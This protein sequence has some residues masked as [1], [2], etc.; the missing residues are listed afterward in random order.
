MKASDWAGW[1]SRYNKDYYGGGL[2]CMV[3]V[4]AIYRGLDYQVG[5]LTSM[6]PG[7]FPVAIGS[8]LALMGLII[9]LGA[10]GAVPS[11]TGPRHRPE[12]RGWSCILLANIAFVLLGHYG[13]LVPATF[14]VVFISALG[15]RQNT[16]KS[17]LVLALAM[18]AIC[19]IV[20]AWGLQL[21]FPLFRWG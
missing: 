12:W 7:Y 9:V 16:W 14:A 11:A 17:A 3:G 5:T 21:Q 1:L 20:F 18:V 13:G 6:G 2:M 4:G 10:R 15:D 8:V 19:I